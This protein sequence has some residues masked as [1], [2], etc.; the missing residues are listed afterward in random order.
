MFFI[1]LVLMNFSEITNVAAL[2]R[3][4][5]NNLCQP[6]V[7]VR[8]DQPSSYD[9]VPLLVFPIKASHFIPL[10]SC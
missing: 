9:M 2:L 3:A 6:M 8:R 1:S 7:V 5:C 10:T 4:D